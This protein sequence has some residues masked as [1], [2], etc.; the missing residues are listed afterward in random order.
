MKMIGCVLGI[1]LFWYFIGSFY[2]TTFNIKY[3]TEATRGM[4]LFFY[5]CTLG[6]YFSFKYLDKI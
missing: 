5:I 3:W 4:I 6:G 1:F 2:S